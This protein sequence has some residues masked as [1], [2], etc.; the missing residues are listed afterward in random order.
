MHK[1]CAKIKMKL[2]KVNIFFV[3]TVFDEQLDLLISHVLYFRYLLLASSMPKSVRITTSKKNAEMGVTSV[4]FNTLDESVFYVGAE[5]GGIF[6]CSTNSQ[7]IPVG[8]F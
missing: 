1:A 3:Y 8:K 7:S 6:K 5:S 2:H 4:S